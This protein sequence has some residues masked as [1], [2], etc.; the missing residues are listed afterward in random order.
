MLDR[1]R[2]VVGGAETPVAVYVH[3]PR[4]LKTPSIDVQGWTLNRLLLPPVEG[5]TPSE[6]DP[7]AM[8]L[9]AR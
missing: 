9:C 8:V 2:H 1:E 6:A 5:L 7:F 3:T 4:R